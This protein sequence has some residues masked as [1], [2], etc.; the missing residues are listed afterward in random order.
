MSYALVAAYLT[1][2]EG[3]SGS[4]I[5]KLSQIVAA[6]KANGLP[7]IIMADWNMTPAELAASGFVE[8]I[9]GVTLVPAQ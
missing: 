7:F 3:A 6:V 9:Q 2:G 5:R 1:T 8:E 4:N